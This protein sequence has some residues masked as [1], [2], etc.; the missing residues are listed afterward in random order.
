MDSGNAH[1]DALKN[2]YRKVMDAMPG[3]GVRVEEVRQEGSKLHI[4]AVAPSD[5]AKNKIWDLIKASNPQYA[6]DLVADIRVQAPV[7]GSVSAGPGGPTA[8]TAAQGQKTYTVKAGDTLSKIAKEHYGS[9]N[10]YNQIFEAN[11]NILKDADHIQPGQV[12]VIPP[13]K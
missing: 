8:T 2:R 13:E 1:F 7:G 12:L 10:K 4:K 5:A 6:V 3:E 11:R 9:A